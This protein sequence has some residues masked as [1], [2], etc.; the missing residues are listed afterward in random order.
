MIPAKRAEHA[1]LRLAFLA[2]VRRSVP[3]YLLIL[4][5]VLIFLIFIAYPVLVTIATSF[6]ALDKTGRI[7]LFGTLANYVKLGRSPESWNTLKQTLVWAA[8]SVSLTTVVGMALALVL[9]HQF[10]G[11]RLVRGLVILPWAVPLSVSAIVW[12]WIDHGQLG[13]L[14]Y[15]VTSLGLTDHY[16]EWLGQPL[17]AFLSAMAVEVWT[18]VPFMAIT[19]LAGLQSIPADVYE[20]ARIDGCGPTAMFR[21][22]TLPLLRPVLTL[23]TLLSVIWSFNSFPI[24]WILTR[25]GPAGSTDIAVTYI[26]KKAFQ[27]FDLGSASAMAV[28]ALVILLG[29]SWGYGKLF[30]PEVD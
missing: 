3:A 19:L 4:P 9:N 30:K 24:I 17:S 5:A 11:R 16:H 1:P 12:R 7:E 22:M 20:A 28:V 18:S 10:P 27:A 15:V 13:A 21:Y 6:S 2:D 8:A 29:F 23:A 14:N 25:G 26:Y